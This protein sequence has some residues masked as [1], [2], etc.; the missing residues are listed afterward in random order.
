VERALTVR[1]LLR[2]RH[3]AGK[4]NAFVFRTKRYFAF[5]QR[6]CDGDPSWRASMDGKKKKHS[7]YDITKQLYKPS[8]Y[9]TRMIICIIKIIIINNNDFTSSDYYT[10][11]SCGIRRVEMESAQPVVRPPSGYRHWH[12]PGESAI[13]RRNDLRSHKTA[14]PGS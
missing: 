3:A 8:Q 1:Y 12:C 5:H 14:A 11:V 9:D 10:L 6:L 7:R 13:R 4:R 2:D